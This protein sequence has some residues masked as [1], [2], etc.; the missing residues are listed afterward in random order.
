MCELQSSTNL[1]NIILDK[2]KLLPI[3]QPRRFA[4]F[5]EFIN[6]MTRVYVYRIYVCRNQ[7]SHTATNTLANNILVKNVLTTKCEIISVSLSIVY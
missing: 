5:S 2:G 7:I 3:T 4:I 6:T 1:S